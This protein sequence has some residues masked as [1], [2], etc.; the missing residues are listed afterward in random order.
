VVRGG[1]EWAVH[2]KQE[3]TGVGEGGGGVQGSRCSRQWRGRE[4][5]LVPSAGA[6]GRKK[7]GRGAGM[8][9]EH[10][11]DEVAAVRRSGWRGAHARGLGRRS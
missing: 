3:V 9:V 8:S 4:M 2:G 5:G 7:K 1:L 6:T 10:G 11:D